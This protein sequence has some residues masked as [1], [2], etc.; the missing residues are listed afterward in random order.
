MEGDD[1]FLREA[2]RLIL[3]REC[4]ISGFINFQ[5][6]LRNRVSRAVVLH[7]LVSSEEAQ[8][9]GTTFTGVWDRHILAGRLRHSMYARIRSG[10]RLVMARCHEIVRHPLFHRFDLLEH[11]FDYF[12]QE[13]ETRTDRLSNQTDQAMRIL[14]E[15]LDAQIDRQALIAERLDQLD[16]A[17]VKLRE[18]TATLPGKIRP[19]AVL[20]GE[21]FSSLKWTASFSE[22]PL[23]N[24]EWLLITRSEACWSPG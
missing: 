21:T 2:Y 12:F 24:G 10:Y 3:G 15:K 17:I 18:E 5:E 22:C 4:D 16:Q 1:Q 9:T 7:N 20:A 13:L 14:S 23:G 6:M 19:A 11:K 8:R